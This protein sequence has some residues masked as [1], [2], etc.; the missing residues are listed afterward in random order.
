MVAL[1]TGI[2][3]FQ[4]TN[5][6]DYR[7]LQELFYAFHGVPFREIAELPRGCAYFGFKQASDP[8]YAN[9]AFAARLRPSGIWTGGETRA[10]AAEQEA[11]SF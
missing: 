11:R 1:A 6:L 2:L 7:K 5:L 8:R 10:V 3:Q 4:G 9:K